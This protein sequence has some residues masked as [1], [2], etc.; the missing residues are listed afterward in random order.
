MPETDRQAF[1]AMGHDLPPRDMDDLT[2]CAFYVRRS[3]GLRGSFCC[4]AIRTAQLVAT[5]ARFWVIIESL[6]FHRPPG[7][8]DP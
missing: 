6:D 1:F 4:A 5:N 7:E 2:A 3:Q 8:V